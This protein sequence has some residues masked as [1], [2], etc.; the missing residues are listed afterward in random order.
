VTPFQQRCLEALRK[1][2]NGI[3]STVRLADR[4]RSSN[5]AVVSAMRALERQGKAGSM[6][7]DDSQWAA[8]LWFERRASARTSD[9]T[10]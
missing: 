8:L 9:P 5:V 6:R 3:E 2:P 1:A 7:S 10:N 4:L